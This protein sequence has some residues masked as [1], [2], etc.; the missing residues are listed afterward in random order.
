MRSSGCGLRRTWWIVLGAVGAVAL[1]AASVSWSAPRRD[2][3]L[4]VS[5]SGEGTLTA[6]GGIDCGE[7]CE[8]RYARGKVV[9]VTATAGNNTEFFGWGADCRGTA[10]A[11]SVLLERATRVRA[12]FSPILQKVS[13][14]VG[15]PGTVVSDPLGPAPVPDRPDGIRC[16]SQ[17]AL[18]T[19]MFGQGRTIILNPT[20]DAD[21]VFAG[22]GRA[23]EGQPVEPV[24][25]CALTVGANERVTNL[26]MAWFRHR[27]AGFGPQTVTVDAYRGRDVRS[28]PEGIACG[29][30]CSADFASGTTVSLSAPDADWSGDCVGVVDPC[31]V[32][33]DA[34]VN[35]TARVSDRK[36]GPAG[37]LEYGV[38]VSVSGRGRVT[39]GSQIICDGK[40]GKSRKCDAGFRPN[41][42]VTLVAKPANRRNRFV[43]WTDPFCRPNAG[44]N[45]RCAITAS[46]NLKL[47]AVF[48]NR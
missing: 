6:P 12:V 1:A 37:V 31:V 24:P 19:A 25:R 16:G 28:S 26:A 13:M 2:F 11:C 27:V 40:S 39:V 35:V 30:V 32:T 46:S 22:W 43:K 8:A 5:V 21:A 44:K 33:A 38:N 15:G 47:Q 3:Q 20:P 34:P 4:D 18:C 9:T 17:S 29:D 41:A 42:S 36:L 14:S 45:P 48:T 10:P 23:C 7:L